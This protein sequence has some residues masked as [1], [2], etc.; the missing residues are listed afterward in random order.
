MISLTSPVETRAHQWPA[1]LKLALLCAVTVILFAQQN[2][3][4][5]SLAFAATLAL[6]ALPGTIF[7]TSG[8]SRLWIL[9]PFLAVILIWHI[10]TG[11][12]AG[13]LVVILRLLS[14]VAL[15][16]L[17]TMTTRLSDM[18]DVVRWL[19]TPLRALGLKTR[20]LELG[21]ALVVRFTPALAD[22]GGQLAQSWSARSPRR[23]NWHIVMPFT[24]LAIDDAEHV[25]EAI[26]ARGG[27]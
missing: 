9:W 22:K 16:N 17:V 1:G 15:A 6:Y 11:D 13:G 27:L 8:L 26:R 20:A 4:F 18:I 23:P 10:I 19:A 2:L 7:L 14:A 21:I 3:A 24:V 5:H 12:T 25:A